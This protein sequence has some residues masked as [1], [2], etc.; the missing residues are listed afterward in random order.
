M[1]NGNDQWACGAP[2]TG[3]GWRWRQHVAARTPASTPRE[4]REDRHGRGEDG[5]STQACGAWEGECE[6]VPSLEATPRPSNSRT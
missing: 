5:S 6:R 4:A 2:L 3:E 1:S